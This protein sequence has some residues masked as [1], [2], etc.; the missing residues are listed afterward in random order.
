MAIQFFRNRETEAL[1][2]GQRVPAF[3]ACEAPAMRKLAMLNRASV[4]ADLQI[5]P[6]NRLD[7]HSAHRAD[8]F[9]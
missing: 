3:A 4:L 5:P 8:D 7:L 6:G 2:N 9:R 1:F